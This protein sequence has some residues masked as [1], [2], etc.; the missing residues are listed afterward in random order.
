[1]HLFV[2]FVT[3]VKT[4]INRK[5]AFT[6]VLTVAGTQWIKQ[7]FER[8]LQFEDQSERTKTYARNLKIRL[9]RNFKPF[10]TFKSKITNFKAALEPMNKT[11]KTLY[12]LIR[13]NCQKQFLKGVLKARRNISTQFV[14]VVFEPILLIRCYLF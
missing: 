9:N 13:W 11:G 5:E 4:N 7:T 10:Q 8:D 1:M 6:I 3:K 2:T 14:A 12:F